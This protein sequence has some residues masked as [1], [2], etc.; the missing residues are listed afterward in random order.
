MLKQTIFFFFIFFTWS[1]FWAK[2]K[3]KQQADLEVN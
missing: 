1:S 2:L 3:E